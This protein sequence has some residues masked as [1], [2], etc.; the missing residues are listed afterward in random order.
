MDG[1]KR[2]QILFKLAD[3]MEVGSILLH[4]RGRCCEES[5]LR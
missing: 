3:L 5:L 1:R 4:P 2:G